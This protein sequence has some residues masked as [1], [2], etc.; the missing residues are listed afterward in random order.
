M[1]DA[2]QAHAGYEHGNDG[3]HPAQHS[4]G[5]PHE[6]EE[7]ARELAKTFLQWHEVCMSHDN[8]R[9]AP[10]DGDTEHCVCI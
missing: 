2:E 5:S 1:E 3:E 6:D 4:K 8:A 9:K 7:L 10:G